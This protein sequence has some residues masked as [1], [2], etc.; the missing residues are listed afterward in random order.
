[1]W[2]TPRRLWSWSHFL[3]SS[4]GDTLAKGET[5]DR[6]LVH[7]QVGSVEGANERELEERCES[8]RPGI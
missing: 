2:D 4:A 3:Y 5:S 6:R 7:D 1:M 8:K